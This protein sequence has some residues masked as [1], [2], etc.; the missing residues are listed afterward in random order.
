MCYQMLRGG[1]IYEKKIA[2]IA[3]LSLVAVT[4]LSGCGSRPTARQTAAR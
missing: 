1:N 4:V 2:V 3:A